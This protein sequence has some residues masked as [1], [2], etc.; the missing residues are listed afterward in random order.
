MTTNSDERVF[1]VRSSAAFVVG[2]VVGT[3]IY[4][5]PGLVASLLGEPWKVFLLW[6]LAGVFTTA[7]AVV[8]SQLA[9]I[10]PQSGGAYRFL[11]RVYGP[12]AASMLLSADVFLG[13]PAAVG[14]LATGFGLVWELSDQ[15]GLIVACSLIVALTM[16]QLRGAKVQGL[17]QTLLTGLQLVPLVLVLATWALLD[18]DQ[19]GSPQALAP[20]GVSQWSA[21]FLAILWA[22]DGWYNLTILGAEV[23]DPERT[24]FRALVGGMVCVTSL[25]LALNGVLFSCLPPQ[26]VAESQVPF[27]RLF[28]AWQ[29]PWLGF[30]LK[31]SLTLALL[32][33]LNGTLAC[34]SRVMVAASQDGLIRAK[35]GTDPTRPLPTLAFSLLCLGLLILFGGLPLTLNLFDSLSE[36]TVVIVVLLTSLSITCIFHRDKLGR[37]VSAAVYGCAIFYL[38]VN[39]VL[40]YLLVVESNWLA[41]WGALSVGVLGTVLWYFRDSKIR[42]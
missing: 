16:V 31:V 7:G 12:W 23:K 30:A 1:G 3:G 29:F 42:N 10:W 28:E 40:L 21:A 17:S 25:Y 35:L 19:G 9:R 24:F 8:Y 41:L 38:G 11:Y 6:A 39:T 22:Y 14:A 5:K 32:A 2:T 37:K 18:H 13:R 27:A 26:V 36:L 4:L 15:E 33:T 20:G 34:G